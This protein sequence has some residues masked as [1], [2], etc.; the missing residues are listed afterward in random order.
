[1]ADKPRNAAPRPV[2]SLRQ[3]LWPHQR[4]ALDRMADAARI[5]F[6]SSMG[7]TLEGADG[8]RRY[9]VMVEDEAFYE[10]TV[11]LAHAEGAA[12][13]DPVAAAVAKAG[14]PEDAPEGWDMTSSVCKAGYGSTARKVRGGT[15]VD[16]TAKIVVCRG[17][18]V[19]VEEGRSPL[20]AAIDQSRIDWPGESAGWTFSSCRGLEA[21][22]AEPIEIESLPTR[23]PHIEPDAPRM[24]M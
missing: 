22:D 1:M 16:L 17:R 14:R 19:E 15:E 6:P 3:R 11:F 18:E 24:G 13:A 4:E 7:K 9:D 2:E 12:P 8:L 21:F 10:R 20:Q 5:E 23:D